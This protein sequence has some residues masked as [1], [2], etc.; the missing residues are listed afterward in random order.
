MPITDIVVP[1][2]A[3][4]DYIVESHDIE[5]SRRLFLFLLPGKDNIMKAVQ[6]LLRLAI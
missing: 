4:P 3:G 5:P 6:T 1:I 2:F